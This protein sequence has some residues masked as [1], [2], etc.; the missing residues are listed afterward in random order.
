MP[1]DTEHVVITRERLVSGSTGH[2]EVSDTT[3]ARSY[4]DGE[5]HTT[6]IEHS[7]PSR[8]PRSLAVILCAYAGLCL[9]YNLVI[10]IGE[11]PDEI[12]HLK[13]VEYLVRFHELPPIGTGDVVAQHPAAWYLENERPYTLEAKQPPTYYLLEAGLMLA[14][15]RSGKLLAPKM[16]HDPTFYQNHVRFLHPPVPSDLLPWVYIMRML[17]MLLGLGT[18]ALTYLTVRE[19]FPGDAEVPLAMAAAA[20]VGLLPQFTFISSVLNN[21]NLAILTAVAISYCMVHIMHRGVTW[22]RT[23]ALGILLGLAIISKTNVLIF[24]PLGMLALALSGLPALTPRMGG[25]ANSREW[26]RTWGTFL[27]RRIPFML[28]AGVVCAAVGG[29]WLLRNLLVYGDVLARN[30]VNQM[31]QQVL[32]AAIT[33]YEVSDLDVHAEKLIFTVDTHF[34]WFG[35]EALRAPDIFYAIYYVLMALGILG[36]IIEAF[37]RKL[38]GWQAA[39]LLLGVFTVELAYISLID[40]GASVGRLIFPTLAF[41]SLL[42]A[43]GTYS[44]LRLFLQVRWAYIATAAIW[45]IFLGFANVYSLVNVIVPGFYKS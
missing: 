16:V 24:V 45:I 3:S 12:K 2:G 30:A 38:H 37:R 21:D 4:P 43:R 22:R 19:V 10:P 29:W 27:K 34:G 23:L 8:F 26:L 9:L 17:G 18:V 32:P 1:S 25:K 28:V 14:L 36:L 7:H 13:Y 41:T 33:T 20:M 15:G 42:I 6:P 31:A 40:H 39:S 35:W 11:G 5:V 44:W